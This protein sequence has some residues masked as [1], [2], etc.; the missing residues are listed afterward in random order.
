MSK[1][2]LTNGVVNVEETY[3]EVLEKERNGDWIE[4]K[5]TNAE[6]RLMQK[7]TGIPSDTRIYININHIQCVKP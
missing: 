4:L 7:A 1:I 5:E 2:I 3:Q 6:L